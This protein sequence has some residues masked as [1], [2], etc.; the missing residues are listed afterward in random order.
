MAKKGA[1]HG[2]P[3]WKE[4]HRAWYTSVGGERVRLA[5]GAENYHEACRKLAELRIVAHVTPPANASPKTSPDRPCEATLRK[6]IDDYALYLRRIG[7]RNAKFFPMAAGRLVSHLKG[8]RAS[9]HT[10][11]EVEEWLA[12]QRRA[13]GE[14]WSDNT[15]QTFIGLLQAA[16]NAALREGKIPRNPIARLRKPPAQSRGA[17]CRVTE[18]QHRALWQAAPP[19]GRDVIATLRDTGTR[20]V[21][22][23]RVTAAECHLS[24]G[25]WV[26]KKHKTGKKT[27]R[28]LVVPLTPTVV[29]IC[30]RLC[31]EHSRGPIYRTP[32]GLPWKIDNFGKRFE[33]WKRK[34]GI[35]AP[36]TPYW[37]RHHLATK[38]LEDGVS[39]SDV[40]AILGHA[41]TRTLH[42][43]YSHLTSNSRRLRD[44]LARHTPPPVA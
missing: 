7:S 41:D 16:F 6:V 40:A 17:I 23:F 11:G 5:T 37:Y 22:V 42:L 34:A 28:A 10:V 29:D 20:P 18:E 1:K 21:N 3:W 30:A 24:A 35:E 2:R 32:T 44:I 43:H 27:G 38:L 9:E 33:G 39:D 13:D 36:I 8:R 31:A 15:T 4:S 12:D 14:P 26:L 25:A 19:A